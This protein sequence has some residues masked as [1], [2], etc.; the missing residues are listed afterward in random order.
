[1]PN[2]SGPGPRL[3]RAQPQ[4]ASIAVAILIGIPA[5]VRVIDRCGV[6]I[7]TGVWVVVCS[8]SPVA[9]GVR[10]VSTI[11]TVIMAAGPGVI[12]GIPPIPGVMVAVAVMVAAAVA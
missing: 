6:S 7:R 8:D 2:G 9:A 3:S 4:R 1:M 11:C 12:V 10:V 5:G